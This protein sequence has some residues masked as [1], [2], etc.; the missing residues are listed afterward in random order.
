MGFTVLIS[1]P[2]KDTVVEKLNRSQDR[3]A[4]HDCSVVV[5]FYACRDTIQHL[6]GDGGVV[7]VASDLAAPDPGEERQS[8]GVAHRV[9]VNV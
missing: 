5:C 7:N 3:V 1:Y 9:D 6:R 4:S 8:E 2:S